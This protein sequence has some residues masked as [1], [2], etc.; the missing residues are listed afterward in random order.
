MS[1]DAVRAALEGQLN[2]ITPALATAWENADFTPAVGTPFQAV[3]LLPAEP[4]NTVFGPTYQ[5]R[6]LMQVTLNYPIGKGAKDALA[7]AKLIRETFQ[8]GLSLVKSGITT[9]IEKTPEIGPGAPEGAW[10]QLPVRV[11]WYANVPS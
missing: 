1:L 5:E 3:N 8:R 10:Y 7:R 9:T 11:R 4:D 2:A 6:G